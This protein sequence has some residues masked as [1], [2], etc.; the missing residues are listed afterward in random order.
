MTAEALI[1]SADLRLQTL[2]ALIGS[3]GLRLLR[4]LLDLLT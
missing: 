1:G 4:L 3:A 2:V